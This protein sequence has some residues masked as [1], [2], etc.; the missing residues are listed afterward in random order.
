MCNSARRIELAMQR[1]RGEILPL[2]VSPGELFDRLT[3]LWLKWELVDD[4]EKKAKAGIESR[5][6]ENY[7]WG[8]STPEMRPADGVCGLNRQLIALLPFSYDV[9]QL[10]T[11]N[12]KLWKIEDD[13]RALDATVF[14]ADPATYPHD[15]VKYCSLARSVYVTNDRRSHWKAEINRACGH[16]SEVK[17][18]AEYKT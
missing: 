14:P 2:S 12:Q 9:T 13:I 17:Q 7:I 3:I 15:V 8:D 6:I 16:D 1:L 18:Y 5:A 10:Y 11:T 4:A